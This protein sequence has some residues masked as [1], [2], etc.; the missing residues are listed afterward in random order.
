MPLLRHDRLTPDDELFRVRRVWIGVGDWVWPVEARYAAWTTAAA[1][2][3][4]LE[5]L[6][7]ATLGFQ[8]DLIHALVM[9]LYVPAIALVATW[10]LFTFVDYERPVLAVLHHLA[11][12]ARATVTTRPRPAT[13]PATLTLRAWAR[14]ERPPR[15]RWRDRLPRRRPRPGPRRRAARR[16]NKGRRRRGGIPGGHALRFT[17]AG[18]VFAGRA[19]V[20][21]L[22]VLFV[23]EP[24]AGLVIFLAVLL[25]AFNPWGGLHG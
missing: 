11:A 20:V 10:G 13:R 24:R 23:L 12:S 15:R 17:G 1:V 25:A 2:L 6:V 3:V 7:K 22:Y 21:V 8:P 14:Q 5:L 4:I 18:L 9:L 16:A 19:V